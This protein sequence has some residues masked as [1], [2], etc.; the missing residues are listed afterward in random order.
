MARTLH[1]YPKAVIEASTWTFLVK[2]YEPSTRVNSRFT[3]VVPAGVAAALPLVLLKIV[4]DLIVDDTDIDQDVD[5]SLFVDDIQPGPGTATVWSNWRDNAEAII[6][7]LDPGYTQA[8]FYAEWSKPDT[9]SM[10][11]D[12]RRAMQIQRG[13]TIP[14]D[15]VHQHEGDGTNTDG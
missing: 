3:H 5:D 6:D 14:G 10:R 2:V 1:V 8:A 9:A 15:S 4:F 12:A 7:G 13:W 11:A